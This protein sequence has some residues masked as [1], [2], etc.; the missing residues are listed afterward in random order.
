V[1]NIE[2][3]VSDIHHVGTIRDFLYICLSRR[4][5]EPTIQI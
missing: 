1:N 4:K 2:K 3:Q 5:S